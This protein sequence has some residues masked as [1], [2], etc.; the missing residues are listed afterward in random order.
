MGYKSRPA[1]LIKYFRNFGHRF[2]GRVLAIEGPGL[3]SVPR[4]VDVPTVLVSLE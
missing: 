2:L 4:S 3:A 1:D